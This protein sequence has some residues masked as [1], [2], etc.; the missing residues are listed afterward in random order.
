MSLLE[1]AKK[2]AKKDK[3]TPPEFPTTEEYK[4]IVGDGL[5]GI[6]PKS[7]EK[8]KPITAILKIGDTKTIKDIDISYT[9]KESGKIIGLFGKQGTGKTKRAMDFFTKGKILYLDSEK[10]AQIIYKEKFTK[11]KYKADID[12]VSFRVLDKNM[13]IDK[14]F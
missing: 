2:S 3:K 7:K 4:T 10:K 6:R 1:K 12:I 8:E 9:S 13:R 11:G 5:K 14:P